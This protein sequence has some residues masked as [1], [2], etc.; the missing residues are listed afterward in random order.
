[1][2]ICLKIPLKVLHLLPSCLR[3][4]RELEPKLRQIQWCSPEEVYLPRPS[5]GELDSVSDRDE[6][7]RENSRGKEA[8]DGVGVV[9]DEEPEY[10]L[11]GIT[12]GY[13]AS[14]KEQ[15]SDQGV[16]DEPLTL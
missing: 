7:W 9:D 1:L 4:L 2:T 6:E 13:P 12:S 8:R 14:V 11:P 5:R 16:L 3:L 10:D 15:R